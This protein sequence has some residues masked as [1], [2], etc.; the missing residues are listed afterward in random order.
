MRHDRAGHGRA[1]RRPRRRPA[2]GRCAL[3]IAGLIA[4]NEAER[5]VV[6]VVACGVGTDPTM[7]ANAIRA[8]AQEFIPLPPD[9]ELIAAVLAAVAR[10]RPADDRRDASDEAA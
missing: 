10:R 1:A 2:D 8:G 9:P 7:A 6:P 4:A 5:I 3:D